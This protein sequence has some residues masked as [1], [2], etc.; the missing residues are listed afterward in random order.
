MA[1]QE[2]KVLS[3]SPLL[4]ESAVDSATS[5]DRD[6]RQRP[7]VSDNKRGH[8]AVRPEEPEEPVRDNLGPATFLHAKDT[9]CCGSNGYVYP[10]KVKMEG[11]SVLIQLAMVDIHPI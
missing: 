1:A 8:F 7:S 5:A 6:S 9:G 2:P 3:A 10:F 4:Y 11:A